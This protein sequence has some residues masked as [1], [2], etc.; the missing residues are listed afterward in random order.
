MQA[1]SFAQLRHDCSDTL[2]HNFLRIGLT[3]IDHVVDDLAT[4]EIGTRNLRLS[5]RIWLGRRYPRCLAVVM[6]AERFVI[7]IE[8]KLSQLPKLIGDVLAGISHGAV[9]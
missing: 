4:A 6:R 8:P 2:S 1:G 9:G 3:R 5:F 7:E